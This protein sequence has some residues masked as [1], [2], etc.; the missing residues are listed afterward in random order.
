MADPR[1]AEI[2]AQLAARTPGEWRHDQTPRVLRDGE[3]N[4][5][6]VGRDI[7]G[8]THSVSA[9]SPT[10]PANADAEFIA[11]APSSI[12]YLLVEL[13]ALRAQLDALKSADAPSAGET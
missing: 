7:M 10:K 2:R 12:E 13:D 4:V 3:W 5:C 11:S 6:V 1:I 9:R 8:E